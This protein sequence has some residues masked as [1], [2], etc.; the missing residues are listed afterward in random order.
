[1]GLGY[2]TIAASVAPSGSLAWAYAL[3]PFGVWACVAGGVCGAVAGVLG[4][5][6]L[7]RLEERASAAGGVRRWSAVAAVLVG[8]WLALVLVPSVVGAVARSRH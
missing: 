8:L 1:M 5:R 7:A 2:R 6:P 4:A 3:W